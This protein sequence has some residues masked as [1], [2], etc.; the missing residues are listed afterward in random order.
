MVVSNKNLLFQGPPFSVAFAVSFRE[1]IPLVSPFHHQE[2]SSRLSTA[3][4]QSLVSH[5]SLRGRQVDQVAAW[6]NPE[7]GEQNGNF[8][9]GFHYF[10]DLKGLP[11]K[12]V[13]RVYPFFLKGFHFIFY[14]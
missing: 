2:A 14:I 8:L 5:F 13:H 6:P 12:G 7:K 9:R 10:H 3:G 11:L 1:G 4:C